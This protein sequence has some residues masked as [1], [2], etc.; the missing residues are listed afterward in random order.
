MESSPELFRITM[1]NLLREPCPECDIEI[2]DLA[3]KLNGSIEIELPLMFTLVIARLLSE[4]LCRVINIA[5][6]RM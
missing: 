2:F 1:S 4:V 3:A 5:L 6:D